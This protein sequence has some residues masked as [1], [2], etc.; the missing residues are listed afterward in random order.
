[1]SNDSKTSNSKLYDIIIKFEEDGFDDDDEYIEAM[2]Y[3][4]D[5]GDAWRLQGFY[6]RAAQ[7]MIDA[8][9]CR[10]KRTHH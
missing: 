10:E 4:I 1:M 8:G 6:G 2:Q 5:T 7:S 9:L 3:L